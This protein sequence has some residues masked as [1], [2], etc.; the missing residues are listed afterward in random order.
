M[1]DFLA[2]M[3]VV[4]LPSML[5]VAWLVWRAA[6]SDSDFTRRSLDRHV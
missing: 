2:G 6:P 5:T 1:L 3:I 4:L